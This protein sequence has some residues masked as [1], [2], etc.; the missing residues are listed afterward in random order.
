MFPGSNPVILSC[1]EDSVHKHNPSQQIVQR[2][3]LSKTMAQQ[4]KRRVNA[5]LLLRCCGAPPQGVYI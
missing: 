3:Q 5:R 4:R 1:G 2:L